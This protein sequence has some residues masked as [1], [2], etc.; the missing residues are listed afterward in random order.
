MVS[1]TNWKDITIQ[2]ESL[3]RLRTFPIGIKLY[4]D[5]KPLEE[6]RNLRTPIRRT[7]LCQSNYHRQRWWLVILVLKGTL[8]FVL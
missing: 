1:L 5:S 7:L 6:I 2:L 3:L 4:E 8:V